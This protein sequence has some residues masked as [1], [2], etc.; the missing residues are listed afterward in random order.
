MFVL[1]NMGVAVGILFLTSVELKIYCMLYTVHRLY[2]LFLVLSRHIGYVLDAKPF[3]FSTSC[4]PAI[5]RK[6]HQSVPVYCKRFKMAD[7]M[8]VWGLFHPPISN[9]KVNQILPRIFR[10]MAV[11]DSLGNSICINWPPF[12]LQN[13][14]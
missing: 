8:A 3:L 4:S 9:T 6:S 7:K 1:E 12:M 5:F 11:C 10:Y 13:C 14:H 2:L